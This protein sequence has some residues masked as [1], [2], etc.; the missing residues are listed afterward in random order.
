MDSLSMVRLKI[1]NMFMLKSYRATA[2]HEMRVLGRQR[3]KLEIL[4]HKYEVEMS[5]S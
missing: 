5:L 3:E 4:L 2:K 1:D